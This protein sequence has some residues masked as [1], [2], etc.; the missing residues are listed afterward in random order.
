MKDLVEFSNA[1]H[2]HRQLASDSIEVMNGP[3]DGRLFTLEAQKTTIGRLHTADIALELDTSVSRAHACLTI[4]N[5]QFFI[6]DLG[7]THGTFVNG[8]KVNATVQLKA[9]DEILIGSTFLRVRLV[10][11]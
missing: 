5:K 2:I 8:E 1:L 4:N 11:D 7:S 9:G 6:E 10:E 3:E